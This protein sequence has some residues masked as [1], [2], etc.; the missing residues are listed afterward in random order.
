MAKSNAVTAAP[1]NAITMRGRL[2]GKVAV[3][4]GAAGN[5]GGHIATHYLAEGATVVLTGRTLL[6][7][8]G[9]P[10]RHSN[11]SIASTLRPPRSRSDS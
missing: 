2:A 6:P 10:S 8:T 1:A 7:A 3:I 4:T 5:L 11:G 9:Q